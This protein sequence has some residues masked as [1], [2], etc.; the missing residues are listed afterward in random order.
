MASRSTACSIIATGSA[1]KAASTWT[2][3]RSRPGLVGGRQVAGG[4]SYVIG[5]E[6]ARGHALKNEA[7]AGLACGRRPARAA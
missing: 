3:G 7:W 4:A 1:S 5:T 6:P 2:G